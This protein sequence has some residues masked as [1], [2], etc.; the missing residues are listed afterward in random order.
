MA[1]SNTYGVGIAGNCCTHGA[2]AAGQLADHPRTRLITGYEARPQRAA[3]LHQAMGV[4]L[5]PSYAEVVQ[6]PQVDIVAITSDPCD[7]AAL[8]ERAAQAGKALFINKPLSHNPAGAQRIEAAVAHVP[9]VFDAPMVK[10]QPAFDK[11]L[12]QVQSGLYGPV[13]SY[14]HM[15]GMT[16]GRDFPIHQ[17]WPERFGPAAVA[18]GGEM[19]NMGCYAIDYALHL[20]GMPRRVEARWQ[21]FWAPYRAAE[22]ENFGQIALDYGRFWAVLAV[23]KQAVRGTRGPRNALTLECEGANL[24]LDPGAG[25]FI[26]TGRARPLDEYL[27][28]HQCLSALDQLIG[29]ME[30]GAPP[31]SDIATAARGV[32]VL[33]GAYQS[34]VQEGPVDLPLERAVNPLFE[35]S[36]PTQ[37]PSK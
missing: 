35:E 3:E 2:G 22:V 15:F 29:H 30:G 27:D 28:G 26:D 18:G 5:A 20:L 17:T 16:F 7:K 24:F 11:L 1:T 21:K 9:A 10:F 8:V 4:P 23:G 19:T 34:I 14:Y 13:V 37:S 12:R 33:C 6:H 31:A 36:P 32:E 25:V